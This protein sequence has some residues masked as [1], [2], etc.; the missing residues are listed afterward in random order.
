MLSNVSSVVENLPIKMNMT[1]NSL[2]EFVLKPNVSL[3]FGIDDDYD[4]FR[5]VGLNFT[6]KLFRFYPLYAYGINQYY[7]NLQLNQRRAS[8][9]R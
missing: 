3:K 7:S 9:Y 1:T 8:D 4:V 2:K 5:S 6:C